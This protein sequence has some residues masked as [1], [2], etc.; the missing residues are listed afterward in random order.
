MKPEDWTKKRDWKYKVGCRLR[1]VAQLGGLVPVLWLEVCIP[2]CHFPE[3]SWKSSVSSVREK[4]NC[5]KLVPK[6]PIL[7]KWLII[8]YL[9]YQNINSWLIIFYLYYRNINK[10]LAKQMMRLE[11]KYPYTLVTPTVT[12]P[13]SCAKPR[14]PTSYSIGPKSIKNQNIGHFLFRF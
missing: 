5:T 14:Q 2:E 4:G 6:F 10:S 3:K 8:F 1:G 11:R 9:Y 7:Q 12:R 13:P